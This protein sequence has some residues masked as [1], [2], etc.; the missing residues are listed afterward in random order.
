MVGPPDGGAAWRRQ[1]R[2]RCRSQGGQRQPSGPALL[3]PRPHR[4]ARWPRPR[5]RA[6]APPGRERGPRLHAGHRHSLDAHGFWGPCHPNARGRRPRG[7][8]LR[9][10]ARGVRAGP[11]RPRDAHRGDRGRLRLRRGQGRDAA[12]G[13]GAQFQW[14]WTV[15]VVRGGHRLDP[16]ERRAAGGD[17]RQYWGAGEVAQRHG[18]RRR[19]CQC[20]RDSRGGSRER[21]N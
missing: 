18:C 10:V 14:R 21:W 5:L 3:G 6:S 9:G 17:L 16:G 20:W 2:S 19:S 7:G 12:R 11:Q 1:P 13:A 8:A 15:V 4:R